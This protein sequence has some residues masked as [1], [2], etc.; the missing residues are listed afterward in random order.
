MCVFFSFLSGF[1]VGKCLGYELVIIFRDMLQHTLSVSEFR[2]EMNVV[3]L[4]LL[5]LLI[6]LR[7]YFH[8]IISIVVCV[9]CLRFS[10]QCSLN[11]SG[12]R[13]REKEFVNTSH[14]RFTRM[15]M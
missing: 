4:P 2:N 12:T 13:E 14:V 7:I 10:V 11:R 3:T 15:I 6:L 5:L 1:V 9:C 8:R